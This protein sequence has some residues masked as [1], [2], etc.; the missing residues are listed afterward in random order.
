MS[1]DQ[2]S[3]QVGAVLQPPQMMRDAYLGTFVFEPRCDVAS[4]LLCLGLALRL[5]AGGTWPGGIAETGTKQGRVYEIRKF[6][7][8]HLT[9]VQDG[10]AWTQEASIQR[11]SFPWP[12][13][14]PCPGPSPGP[15]S[16]RLRS[17]AMAFFA[18]R[19]SHRL[20][21][22]VLAGLLL[23]QLNVTPST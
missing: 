20:A 15:S 10:K 5:Q 23:H 1:K 14:L 2:A 16:S 3:W 8:V 18:R 21:G 17:R 7:I 13:P 22:G 11:P 19:L 6:H 4:G 12:A 9:R